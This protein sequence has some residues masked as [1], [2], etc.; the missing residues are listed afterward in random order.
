MLHN[1]A[2]E[3]NRTSIPSQAANSEDTPKSE[4][5]ISEAPDNLATDINVSYYSPR[6]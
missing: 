5:D 6:C 1:L 4:P 2:F 3:F